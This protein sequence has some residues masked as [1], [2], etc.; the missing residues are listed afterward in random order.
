VSKK[1]VQD[2]IVDDSDKKGRF[3]LPEIDS[4]NQQEKECHIKKGSLPK[5]FRKEQVKLFSLL[6]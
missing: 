1:T 2:T 5:H 6:H 3:S 4:S